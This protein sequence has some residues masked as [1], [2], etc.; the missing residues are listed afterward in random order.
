MAVAA[1]ARSVAYNLLTSSSFFLQTGTLEANDD[2]LLY[3]LSVDGTHCRIEEPRPFSTEWSSHKYGGKPAVNYE[4]GI[5]LHK[6]KLVWC[7]GP[8]K[9]GKTN[10][11]GVFKEAL[12]PALLAIGKR[13]IGDGIYSS[14]TEVIS[15][16]N[17]FDPADIAKF[18]NRSL[19]RHEK[20]N[21]L[22]KNFNVL[23]QTFRH[24]HGDLLVQHRKHFLAVLVLVQTQLDNGGFT[25][26]DVYP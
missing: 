21:G 17:D 24:K 6:A 1:P 26:F 19:A 16:K 8:T 10:D 2:G 23:H 20:F 7:Y 4:L 25:L 9:P 15:S 3:M 22:L 18:K 12:G 13:A 5:L 11:L 14:Y